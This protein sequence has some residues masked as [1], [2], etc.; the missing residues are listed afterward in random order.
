MSGIFIDPGKVREVKVTF[1]DKDYIFK[2]RD[3]S[4]SRMNQILNEVNTPMKD[5]SVKFDIDKYYRLVLS[6]VV[7]ASPPEIEL[8]QINMTRLTPEF[9]RVLTEALAPLPGG[10]TAAANQFPGE[11]KKST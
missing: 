11:D 8:N 7:V 10:D 1:E 2:V 5:G 3:I 4:W 6:E 9:G